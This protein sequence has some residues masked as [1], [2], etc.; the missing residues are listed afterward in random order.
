MTNNITT[1]D[2]CLIKPHFRNI[3]YIYM[4][5]IGSV[6]LIGILLN[7]LCIVTL[8]KQKVQTNNSFL[9]RVLAICDI[10]FCIV[11]ILDLSLRMIMVYIQY[12]DYIFTRYDFSWGAKISIVTNNLY[13]YL[14]MARNWYIVLISA[15]RCFNII[16]PLRARSIITRSRLIV[17]IIFIAIF[18]ICAHFFPRTIYTRIIGRW[19]PCRKYF[20]EK[21][22]YIK[23]ANT[24]ASD[25]YAQIHYVLL[26]AGLPLALTFCMNIMLLITIKRASKE[27]SKLASADQQKSASTAE[28]TATAMVLGMTTVFF[29]CETPGLIDRLVKFLVIPGWINPP[30][31]STQ[32]YLIMLAQL[33]AVTDS[34]VNFF[35]YFTVNQQFRR[36]F[37]NICGRQNK[38][39]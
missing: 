23:W 5:G 13:Y 21:M 19:D 15:E 17:I 37:V 35:A 32:R 1:S 10:L 11:T 2:A 31:Y 6:S 26:I 8:A 25:E 38:E 28:R 16:S 33:M 9:L 29:T 22:T 4:Y 14:V 24:K 3:A 36:N 18:S 39:T 20:H 12:G 27:R 30:L 34:T 7:T